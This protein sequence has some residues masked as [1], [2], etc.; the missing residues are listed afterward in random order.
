MNLFPIATQTTLQVEKTDPSNSQEGDEADP[1]HLT[2]WH[3]SPGGVSR[4]P[5]SPSFD[6]ILSG[7]LR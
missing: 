2:K 1:D 7:S 5:F 3:G 6:M 4:I